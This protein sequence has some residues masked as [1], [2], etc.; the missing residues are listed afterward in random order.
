[1]FDTTAFDPAAQREG[2][3]D[4]WRELMLMRSQAIAVFI[5]SGLAC[6]VLPTRSSEE[7]LI[8][9]Y[10]IAPASASAPRISPFQYGQ[11]IEYLCDLVPGMWADLLEDGSFEG[12]TP[13]AFTFLKETDWHP[14]PWFPYG[15][16][17]RSEYS[18]DESEPIQGLRCMRIRASE[19]APC[20]VGIAQ[21]GVPLRRS[22]GYTLTA[23]LRADSPR[24]VD[25]RLIAEGGTLAS[26]QM[27]AAGEWN[28]RT[29]HLTP[30]RS[31]ASATLTLTFRGPGTIWLDC[32][33]LMPDDAVG[34]WRR[35]VVEAVRALKPGVIRFGG[36]VVDYPSYGDYDW[37]K[38]IGPLEKRVPFRSWGGLQPAGAGLE[39]IVQFIRAVGA[40]PL[41]CVRFIGSTPEEAA[42]QVEYFNGA[43]DTPN[44]AW[45]VRNGHAEPYHIR[46]WQVGNEV[47]SEEYDRRMA[48]FCRAM[49]RADPTIRLLSSYP[50]E[51]VIESGTGLVDYLCPHHYGCADLAAMEA[52]IAGI[53][54]AIARHAPNA[55]FKLGITEWNTTA[56]DWGP[57]RATL[58]T[59]ANALACSR[60]HNLMHRHADIVE[61]ANRSNLTNSFCS[62]IIQTRPGGLYCTPTYYAQR[63]YATHAGTVPL[64]LTSPA[65]AA[66]DVSATAD[67]QS[68][69]VAVFVVN[70]ELTPKTASFQLSELGVHGGA[71]T[72]T[73]LT[74]RQAA[75][76]PDVT[77]SPEYPQRVAPRT[78]KASARNGV[79]EWEFQ[80]LSLTLL[81]WTAEHSVQRAGQEDVH[82]RPNH[83]FPAGHTQ[84]VAF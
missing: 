47:R 52:D 46:F 4:A 21:A 22:M 72:V 65:D 29:V 28:K 40:E 16:V 30:N 73:V 62:G 63:L 58:W 57:A 24:N 26:A 51:A 10:T 34:G 66:L 69:R 6:G 7:T 38:T 19:G 5:L 15:A 70:G 79:L 12:L 8:P 77:N 45:R 49:K 9:V 39:E 1:M 83:I 67:P 59:L 74:D 2:L 37:R 76:E 53:Q 35:D 14:R 64:D 23:Y 50:T 32:V 41:I 56:G 17:N 78:R 84:H 75:G 54:K 61:I 82:L 48:D 36:S 80:P 81:E 27:R 44:G 68:L 31:C 60:Y 18:P 71:V 25:A 11:F 43:A 42:A 13:Y 3:G 55:H 20:T 33:S